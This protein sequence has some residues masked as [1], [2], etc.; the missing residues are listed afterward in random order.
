MDIHRIRGDVKTAAT[1]LEKN[2][3]MLTQHFAH[4]YN[5]KSLSG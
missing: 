5:N 1:A 2:H 3:H 4:Y